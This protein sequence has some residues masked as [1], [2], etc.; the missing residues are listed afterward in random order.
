M[1]SSRMN[2]MVGDSALLIVL[3]EAE[4]LNSSLLHP[5]VARF[6]QGMPHREKIFPNRES[7]S[8]SLE[9]QSTK[10]SD[11]LI[12]SNSVGNNPIVVGSW[13]SCRQKL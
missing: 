4:R 6:W 7:L 3:T 10:C 12:D 13:I 8:R 2:S 11:S 5:C 9:I 1:I